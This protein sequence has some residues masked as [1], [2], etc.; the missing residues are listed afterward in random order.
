LELREILT[1]IYQIAKKKKIEIP[2]LTNDDWIKY[3][4]I[5]N[6]MEYPHIA[7]VK[8][9]AEQLTPSDFFAIWLDLKLRLKKHEGVSFAKR[10]IDGMTA[11]EKEKNIIDSPIVLSSVFLDSR[12]RILLTTQQKQK[13]RDNLTSLWQRMKKY[14]NVPEEIFPIN[15]MDNGG[16][17]FDNLMQLLTA[18][19]Q[20][21]GNNVFCCD[22]ENALH[23]IE[24]MPQQRDLSDSTLSFW[25]RQK[26][27][28]PALY[29]LSKVVNACAPTQVCV[30]RSFS[31]L[32][33]ILNPYRSTL[34]DEQIENVLVVRQN[35]DILKK[36]HLHEGVFEESAES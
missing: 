12:Y 36:F 26:V 7:T 32:A 15:P 33:Y 11:R 14:H 4:E 1:E 10:I 31:G 21:F 6:I 30:E 3:E 5:H 28:E 13:A 2:V 24:L 34:S 17:N 16:E 22:D 9:Q 18:K 19:G 23:R 27:N 29:K 35:K 20:Q 25:S 8:M